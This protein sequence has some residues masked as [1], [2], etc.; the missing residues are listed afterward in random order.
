MLQF[1]V[2]GSEDMWEQKLTSPLVLFAVIVSSVALAATGTVMVFKPKPK[3]QSSI[4]L[5]KGDL[6]ITP[7]R[8]IPIVQRPKLVEA[9]IPQEKKPTTTIS[10]LIKEAP[11]VQIEEDPQ[12]PP[13][14]KEYKRKREEWLKRSRTDICS[15]TGGWRVDINHGRSWRCAYR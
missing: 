4:T 12:P 5:G 10:P 6:P 9:T 15:R 13:D 14:P 1:M 2:N 3:D 7:I 8:V 11:P